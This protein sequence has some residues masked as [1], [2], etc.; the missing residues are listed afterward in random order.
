MFCFWCAW[1]CFI[2][3]LSCL[4][5][6]SFFFL[7]DVLLIRVVNIR[8]FR[9]LPFHAMPTSRQPLCSW[10]ATGSW[11]FTVRVWAAKEDSQFP[12]FRVLEGHS[13]NVHAVTFSKDGMLVG[14]LMSSLSVCT[15]TS[16]CMCT[17][18]CMMM[19][20]FHVYKCTSVCMCTSMCVCASVHDDGCIACVQMRACVP[21][22]TSMCM[23]MDV[24]M[25]CM[26]TSLCMVMDVFH[27]SDALCCC[28]G[29]M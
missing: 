5:L 27:A 23:S 10:Q 2:G 24:R 20:V 26:C 19:D 1:F 17:S 21:V 15:R 13:G 18:G 6:F 28:W 14:C 22:C 16:G 11:D 12:T 3:S 25:Y 9:L 8:D 4:F 29:L 7:C